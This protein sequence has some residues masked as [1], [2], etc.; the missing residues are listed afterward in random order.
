MTQD[1]DLPRRKYLVDA[2]IAASLDSNGSSSSKGRERG[3]WATAEDF[4]PPAAHPAHRS[5]DTPD[6]STTEIARPSLSA[7]GSFG[8]SSSPASHMG[9]SDH[10]DGPS[11]TAP[12]R[13]LSLS[14][15]DWQACFAEEASRGGCG[16]GGGGALGPDGY[17]GNHPSAGDRSVWAAA[18][19]VLPAASRP[20]R[21]KK[22]LKV[23]CFTLAHV[24]GLI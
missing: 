16:G 5:K 23:A 24:L 18:E 22:Q 2:G 7:A 9:P 19:D 11:G 6:G 21:P 14:L 13:T 4:F 17:H 20:G 10:A 15:K 8:G 1:F 3:L 12:S